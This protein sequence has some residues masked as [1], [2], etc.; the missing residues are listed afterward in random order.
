MHVRSEDVAAVSTP[1][2]QPLA[3]EAPAVR[4]LTA[5]EVFRE[6]GA[7]VFRL[8]RRLGIADADLDDLTQDVFVIVHRS[9]HRYEERNHMR[10]WL[11]RIAV[12]EASRHRR[13]LQPVSSFDV[14]ELTESNAADPEETVQANE[15]RADFDRLLTVLDEERRTVF[16][17]YEVEELSMEEVASV[18]GC[19]VPTA[20]SRLRSA[21]KLI[22]AG[23]KRLEAQR[24]SS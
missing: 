8:L 17:L 11:Y 3:L 10:A 23:A 7:F 19:P 5:A 9:L 15:A 21:R 13:S 4:L 12:R 2:E 20:Y 14:E 22:L 6:H 24:R 18:V 16:V 1:I